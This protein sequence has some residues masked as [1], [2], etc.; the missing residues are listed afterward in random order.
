MEIRTFVIGLFLFL[1]IQLSASA[2][3]YEQCIKDNLEKA[4]TGAAVKLLMDVCAKEVEQSEH[5]C[6]SKKPDDLTNE[7]LC[8]CLGALY[9]PSTKKCQ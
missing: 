3:P 2:G 8:K 5:L 6:K 1:S 7:E 9:D 4:K